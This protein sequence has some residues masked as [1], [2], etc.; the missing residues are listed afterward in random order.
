MYACCHVSTS[1]LTWLISVA[2]Q[3]GRRESTATQLT[4]RPSGLLL[5]RGEYPSIADGSPVDAR[6]G[7][8]RSMGCY[9]QAVI[10]DIRSSGLALSRTIFCL[11]VIATRKWILQVRLSSLYPCQL[12]PV[13]DLRSATCISIEIEPAII[14]R[15]EFGD[16]GMSCFGTKACFPTNCGF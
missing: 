7:P 5:I 14:D 15:Q 6:D 13:L 9:E 11:L 3:S 10:I 2:N 1:C 4:V 12:M 16:F 8:S